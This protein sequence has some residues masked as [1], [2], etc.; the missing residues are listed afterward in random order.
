MVMEAEGEKLLTVECSGMF[1]LRI[2]FRVKYHLLSM[3]YAVGTLWGAY[4]YLIF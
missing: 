4:I 2:G 1:T 3:Y